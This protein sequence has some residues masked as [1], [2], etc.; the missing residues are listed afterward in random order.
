MSLRRLWYDSGGNI[1]LLIIVSIT[2]MLIPNISY[3]QHNFYIST[4]GNDTWNGD[5]AHP[6]ATFERAQEAVRSVIHKN[7]PNFR[8]TVW[9]F[10]GIYYFTKTFTLDSLDSGT[11]NAPVIYRAMPGQKVYLVGGKELPTSAFKRI[12]DSSTLQKITTHNLARNYVVMVDLKSLGITDYG[13]LKQCGFSIPVISAPMELFFNNRPMQL[14]RYP[15]LY[16]IT[17]GEIMDPGSIPR[18]GDTSNR[19]GIFR[20]TDPHESL[21]AGLKDIWLQ[22]TFHWGYADDMIRVDSIDTVKHE[23]RLAS[24]HLYG[25]ASDGKPY[26]HY[27][28]LNILS[29]LDNPGEYYIDRDSGILY[30]WPPEKLQGAKVF[31]SMLSQPLIS[32]IHASHIIIRGFTFEYGR[33]LGIYIE[34]GGHNLIAG[35]TIRDMGTAGILMGKGSEPIPGHSSIEGYKGLAVRGKIGDLITHLYN[36]KAWNRDAGV[37]QKVQSCDIYYTGSGGIFLSGGDKRS[38]TPG[39]C[40]VINCRIHDF[41]R[42]NKFHYAGIVVDGVGDTVAHNEIYNS[43]YQGI[44][45]I[46]G[47][48][49]IF[50]YNDIHD[51]AMNSDDISP[52]YIGGDPSDRGNIIKYNYFHN[53]GKKDR[54]VMGVYLDDGACGTT[55]FGNIFYKTGTYGTVY[56]N[57]GSDNI[58][59]N[60][61]FISSYGPAVH[62]KSQWYDFAKEDIQSYFGPNGLYRTRLTKTVDIYKPPYS[63]KYPNLKH[64]LDLLPDGKTFVG[65]RPSGNVMERNVV[66]NCLTTL[67]LTG[68]Y[69]QFDT[70]QNF[71]TD[72]DP[73]FVNVEHQNFQL[74]DNSVVYK[75]LKGFRKIPFERIGLEK[76]EYRDF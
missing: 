54:L 9:V 59:K 24:P 46:S 57:S 22:G 40:A 56:S 51:V 60:N 61:I 23:M 13:E 69:A 76:D 11:A 31:V 49:N 25:L 39:H 2:L 55:V 68:E 53:I 26:Q 36:D 18:N 67:R 52:F 12:K 38:L 1:S 34:G 7:G 32:L 8:V 17:M 37:Y 14:A 43:D 41:N 48:D 65:M 73:G 74:K 29:E 6:F 47:N 75:I 42:W 15:N 21:W 27:I 64:F 5:R 44:Y 35:C 10:G 20:Y 58:I 19:G 45:V 71:V 66:Y 70:L 50:E 30:F 63:T 3:E 4:K 62:L 16:E 72:N 33:G 28:A